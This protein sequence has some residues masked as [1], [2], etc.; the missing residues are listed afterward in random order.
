MTPMSMVQEPSATAN[1][2][3]I[4][5]YAS[6]TSQVLTK[7]STLLSFPTFTH[8]PSP[9]P[10]YT[11][12]PTK[13]L[14]TQPTLIPTL[15]PEQAKSAIFQLLKNNSDCS[16]PCFWGIRPGVDI[17]TVRDSF[18]HLGYKFQSNG[19]VE[20][21]IDKQIAILSWVKIQDGKVKNLQ[22]EIT[23]IEH[24]EIVIT[25]QDWQA[26]RVDSILGAYGKPSRIGVDLDHWSDF[27]GYQIYFIYDELDFAVGYSGHSFNS[28]PTLQICLLADED[29]D[30]FNFWI[31]KDARGYPNPAKT[32]EEATSLS[33][34]EFYT[35]IVDGKENACFN[36]DTGIFPKTTQ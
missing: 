29:I 25:N 18:S 28:E 5:P 16:E 4:S 20:I 8:T 17:Q 10:T 36:I 24:P 14:T 26:F 11:L 34:D 22:A 3:Q 33:L 31:G 7:T 6:V 23:E 27:A 15:K 30:R 13:T 35:L 12:R 2:L 9:I 1:V 21:E 32:V 19:F